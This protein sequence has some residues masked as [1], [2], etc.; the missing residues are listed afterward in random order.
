M[1]EKPNRRWIQ[2]RLRTLLLF[3]LAVSIGTSWLGVRLYRARQQSEAAEA[4]KL[5]RGTV[6]YDYQM[7][8]ANEIKSFGRRP[9]I[10]TSESRNILMNS[11]I[12]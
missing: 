7:T 3:V 2:F 5:A 12:S 6:Y 1:T 11:I 4:I 10:P 9:L 8:E